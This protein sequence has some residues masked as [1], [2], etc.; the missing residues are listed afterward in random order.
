MTKKQQQ[1]IRG[2]GWELWQ[3]ENLFVLSTEQG[4]F[5]GSDLQVSTRL[6]EQ[7]LITEIQLNDIIYAISLDIEESL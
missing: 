6:Y 3:E 1:T 7:N 2:L 4:I 5:K